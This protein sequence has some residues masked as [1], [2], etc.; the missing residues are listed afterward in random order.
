MTIFPE[1][2]R[3]LRALPSPGAHRGRTRRSIR[4]GRGVVPISG[5][6]VAIVIAAVAL[7]PGHGS[8]SRPAAGQPSVRT[9][10][11]E[12]LRSFAILRAPQTA[13]GRV[14]LSVTALFGIGPL[15]PGPAFAPIEA[16]W[17][18]PREDRALVRTVR[19]PGANSYVAILPATYRPS[20][21]STARSEGIDLELAQAH[22]ATG[23]GPRP[24]AVAEVLNHGLA[25]VTGAPTG[26]SALAVVLVPDGVTRVVF[27]AG[28]PQP[29]SA[30]GGVDPLALA[31]AIG[32]VTGSASVHDNI[33]VLSFPIPTITS[34]R[35]LS[36]LSGI[37]ATAPATWYRADGTVIRHTTTELD[38]YV[39]VRGRANPFSG[40]AQRFS[41]RLQQLHARCRQQPSTCPNASVTN[42]NSAAARAY[43]QFRLYETFGPLSVPINNCS[44]SLSQ[45]AVADDGTP[46]ALTGIL[47]ILRTPPTP[48]DRLAAS[49]RLGRR[50]LLWRGVVGDHVFVRYVRLA[51]VVAGTSYYIVPSRYVPATPHCIAMVD[52]NFRGIENGMPAALRPRFTAMV[53]A[54]L[55]RLAPYQGVSL[56]STGRISGGGGAASAATIEEGRTIGTTESSSGTYLTEIVPDGVATVELDFPRHQPTT[57]PVTNNLVVVWIPHSAPSG[58]PSTVVWRAAS[59]AVVRTINP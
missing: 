8:P 39:R 6:V 1:F 29:K 17:G 30:P 40:F 28:R 48:A 11:A 52:H 4:I 57:A 31:H 26:G 24:T 5:T 12:L 3:Q 22:G 53:D 51:R 56:V 35:A 50:S 20:P 7:V 15:R 44:R 42:P 49:P 21:S 55:A 19:L 47:G 16:R 38:L 14:P 34:P 18:Y 25:L 10:R 45:P 33:A 13:A 46:S 41:H 59:G 54:R 32:T 27:G 23:S 58:F 2:E 37:S 36:G 43:E 9:A